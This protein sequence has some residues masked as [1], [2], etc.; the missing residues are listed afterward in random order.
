MGNTNQYH[1]ITHWR[2]QASPE[3]IYDILD[4]PE[5]LVQWWP[6]VYR[7][8]QVIGHDKQGDADRFALD[9]KGWLP[10]NLSWQFHTT[11]KIPHRRL[12]LEAQGDFVGRGIWRIIANHDA[13]DVTYDWKIRAEKPLLRFFSF[14]LK[15]LFSANHHW[16]MA[17]G[18]E[19][20]QLELARRRA[21]TPEERAL[22]PPPPGPSN[23]S[24]F[25]FGVLSLA[26]LII[27]VRKWLTPGK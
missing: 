16:A 20:M 22:V 14:L 5:S 26:L 9:T 12:A 8:V 1:F 3:E 7:H 19:S 27:G 25:W 24:F 15:P 13:V 21:V 23:D 17:K 18:E 6:S 2:F 4:E 10:Y 11:E